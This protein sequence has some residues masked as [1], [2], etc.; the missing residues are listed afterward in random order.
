MREVSLA[1]KVIGILVALV[2]F[3][4]TAAVCAFLVMLGACWSYGHSGNDSF[5]ALGWV[6]GLGGVWLSFVLALKAYRACV[7]EAGPSDKNQDEKQG[8]NGGPASFS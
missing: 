1:R 2:V 8:M 5:S 6:F 3:A 4:L 7:P